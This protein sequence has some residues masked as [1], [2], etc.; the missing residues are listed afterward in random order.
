MPHEHHDPFPD[1]PVDPDVTR[2]ADLPPPRIHRGVL[3]VVALGGAAG[4]LARWGLAEALPHA[5][6]RFPW[7][8]LV[9]NV[10]G[11]FLIGV[12]LVLVIER[13]PR[14][15]L[16][17]PFFGTGILGGFTTF[18]TSMVDTRTLLAAGRPAVAAAYL[19]GTL[20]AA[21]LA[22]VVGLLLT[23]RLVVPRERRHHGRAG[24]R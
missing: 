21:L 6:G 22:V 3:G 24:G 19:L 13:L 8:T 7:A 12:L 11:C 5:V 4:A 18:S 20:M 15:R 16:V 9:T 10:V 17:R 14:Q 23:E 2:E 1:L